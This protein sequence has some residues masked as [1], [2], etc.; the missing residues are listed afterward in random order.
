MAL[1]TSYLHQQVSLGMN[2]KIGIDL[3]A[4]P[5]YSQKNRA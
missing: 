1:K 4:Q 3:T 2:P 5:N